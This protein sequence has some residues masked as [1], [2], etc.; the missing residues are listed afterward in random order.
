LPG[1][2]PSRERRLAGL[3]GIEAIGA[4]GRR[5]SRRPCCAT[6][7]YGGG[8]CGIGRCH[9]AGRAA[10]SVAS[11]RFL[12]GAPPAHRGVGHPTTWL[13]GSTPCA[14]I[15]RGSARSWSR[16]APAG[17]APGS[18]RCIGGGPAG[19]GGRCDPGWIRSPVA[20]RSEGALE[21]GR[22]ADRDA[23]TADHARPIRVVADGGQSKHT[24]GPRGKAAS[25]MLF[26]GRLGNLP[27][28][29]APGRRFADML[30]AMWSKERPSAPAPLL[31]EVS[32]RGRAR[33][34]R[35]SRSPRSPTACRRLEARQAPT[36]DRRSRPSRS[37]ST[38]RSATLL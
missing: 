34:R 3:F 21:G 36:R 15:E 38:N 9:V 7:G 13:A 23:F 18:T 22:R 10:R 35:H 24:P 19:A 31:C 28:V 30:D 14:R 26:R 8:G 29:H 12:E 16:R 5:K 32:P 1:G 6:A 37:T 11:V 25:T 17:Q 2:N 27:P 20:S 4:A 33:R